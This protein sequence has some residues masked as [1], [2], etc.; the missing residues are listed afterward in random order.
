MDFLVT[1][2][3]YLGIILFLVLTGCGLP[4]PEEVPI[5]LAGA[6]SSGPDPHLNPW[7]AFAACLLG[8]LIGDSVMYWIGYF[9]GHGLGRAHPFFAK[10]IHAE[11]EHRFETVVERHG[12]K[13]LLT[14][15]F[16][17]G[18]RAPVYLAAGVVRM[19]FRRFLL[20]DLV[21][22][23]L[24]VSL[25]FGLAHLFG[26]RVT[27]WIRNA[28][29]TFTGVVI[30]AAMIVG[31]VFWRRHRRVDRAL[32]NTSSSSE[33]TSESVADKVATATPL[34]DE[35]RHAAGSETQDRAAGM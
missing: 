24:V 3:S 16:M 23:T 26:R 4:I 29:L 35:Q 8:C 1:H 22:A 14:A 12:F 2:G 32:I 27:E 31:L 6:L 10:L 30:I 28:G 33:G 20:I 11:R 9:G 25:F 21:A 34:A 18:V 13:F 5:V 15:R 7:L 17:V 19:P